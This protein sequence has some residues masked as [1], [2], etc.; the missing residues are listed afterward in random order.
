MAFTHIILKAQYSQDIRLLGQTTQGIYAADP[1]DSIHPDAIN[2]YYGVAGPHRRRGPGETGAGH[3]S[4]EEGDGEGSDNDSE[5]DPEEELENQIRADQA[6]NIR[7]SPVKVARHASPFDEDEDERAF[8]ELLGEVLSQ[9]DLVPEDY[10]VTEE[11]WEDEHYPETETIR[12]GTNGKEL[13]V[14]LPRRY[15]FP[16]AVQ[17]AQALDLLTRVLEELE[18]G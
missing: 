7:H 16:R 2:R 1:L 9:P 11:E 15:W 10:G 18:N 4:D 5:L 8:L 6:Q 3:A 14:E 17:W 12:T 13:V